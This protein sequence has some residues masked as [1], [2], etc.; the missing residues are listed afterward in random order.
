[1]S[2]DIEN[3]DKKIVRTKT[4]T[5]N[6][7]KDFKPEM[8]VRYIPRHA[9]GDINHKDCENGIVSSIGKTVVFVKYYKN[10]I[11][12]DTAQATMP[13]QLIIFKKKK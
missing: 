6:R 10:G 4:D 2:Y 13:N 3:S 8:E 1:M 9:Y 5:G 11:L 12:Q 7:L